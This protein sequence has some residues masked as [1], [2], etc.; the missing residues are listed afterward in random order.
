[1][2]ASKMWR[3]SRNAQFKPGNWKH[4][5]SRLVKYPNNGRMKGKQ[6]KVDWT[7]ST[8]YSFRSKHLFEP[9]GRGALDGEHLQKTTINTN[10]QIK[11]ISSV[12]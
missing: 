5:E 10:G 6:T 1:M 3:D 11:T 4:V 9:R 7:G 8:D 2:I 12:D